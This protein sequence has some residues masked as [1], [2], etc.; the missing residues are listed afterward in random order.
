VAPDAEEA[1]R[2]HR[3]SRRRRRHAGRQTSP[4]DRAAP[5]PAR[6]R[7]ATCSRPSIRASGTQE[8]RRA[9][10]R[11]SPPAQQHGCKRVRLRGL[12]SGSSPPSASGRTC[13]IYGGSHAL[14]LARDHRRRQDRARLLPEERSDRPGRRR[15]SAVQVPRRQ[16]SQRAGR[17][18]VHRRAAPGPLPEQLPVVQ[19]LAGGDVQPPPVGRAGELRLAQRA[20]RLLPRRRS[21]DPERH[22]RR[23]QRPGRQ[24]LGRRA[25]AAHQPA[26]RADRDPEARASRR[27]SRRRST[28]T[29]R[30]APT[31][32]PASTR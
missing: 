18:A 27:S 8:Q 6:K 12:N 5:S 21:P 4:C 26:E 7:R 15:A 23:R 25:R 9:E 20:R 19:R 22:Q 14:Y 10:R 2:R 17:Q 11:A 29:A 32:S 24:R 31:P 30:R 13:S 28:W 16:E 3:R 1:V